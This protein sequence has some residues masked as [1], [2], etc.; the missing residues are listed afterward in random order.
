MPVHPD[1]EPFGGWKLIGKVIALPIDV[2]YYPWNGELSDEEAWR[3]T[4]EAIDEA[5]S[6][7]SRIETDFGALPY[8]QVAN[9]AR[10][11]LG[12]PE[13]FD[14]EIPERERKVGDSFVETVAHDES[15]ETG[16]ALYKLIIGAYDHADVYAEHCGDDSIRPVIKHVRAIREAVQE[17]RN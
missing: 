10:G 3:E 17:E 15:V 7:L 1:S 16:R 12:Y 2:T 5:E 14:V 8:G 6:G 9:R 13:D 11:M 4:D